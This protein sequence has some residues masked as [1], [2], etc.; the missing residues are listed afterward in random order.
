M[1]GLERKDSEKTDRSWEGFSA[2]GFIASIELRTSTTP[3][4]YPL[5]LVVSIGGPSSRDMT[6]V[7]GR[8]RS[9]LEWRIWRE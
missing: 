7:A 2:N 4:S 6:S 3:M 1:E 9:Q 5:A 8:T